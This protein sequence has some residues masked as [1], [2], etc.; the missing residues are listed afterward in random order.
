MASLESV[1]SASSLSSGLVPAFVLLLLLTIFLTALCSDCNRRSFELKDPESAKSPPALIRVVRLEEVR[2]NPMI[3][4]I[5]KDEKE[6]HP[7]EETPSSPFHIQQGEP[8]TDEDSLPEE[9]PVSFIPWRSHLVAP[10]SKDL[11]G[12]VPSDS[13]HLFNPLEWGRSNSNNEPSPSAGDGLPQPHGDGAPR[14]AVT[15]HFSGPDRNSVY[16]RVSKKL[17]LT[18]S[19]V[20]SSEVKQ[21]EQ[22]EAGGQEEEAPPLPDRK[23]EM[24]E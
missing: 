2:E 14:S 15:L 20:H 17:R 16:A 13:A 3:Q 4:E 8:K 7:K 19:P 5:Q 12:S 9:T 18:D 23:L 10:E 1:L 22:E 11:N 21:E 24:D 6:F